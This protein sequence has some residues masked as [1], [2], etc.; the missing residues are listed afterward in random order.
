MLYNYLSNSDIPTFKS[1]IG[2]LA[3]KIFS[4]ES[5]VAEVGQGGCQLYEQVTGQ[6]PHHATAIL[7][8]NK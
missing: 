8:K 2:H 6:H 7:N 4:I 5:H 3:T 1:S